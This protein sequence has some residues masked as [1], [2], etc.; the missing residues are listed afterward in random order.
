[1]NK[2]TDVQKP[3]KE[4]KK[5]S[6]RFPTKEAALV[7]RGDEQVT[8]HDSEENRKY[9]RYLAKFCNISPPDYYNREQI[10]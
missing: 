2:L 4:K 6:K 1:M 8:Y 3:K 5:P 7:E 10:P 9:T